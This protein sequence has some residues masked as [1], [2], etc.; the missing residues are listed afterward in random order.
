MLEFDQVPLH[1]HE[2]F[3]VPDT[4]SMLLGLHAI[5]LQ[6]QIVFVPQKFHENMII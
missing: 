6:R 2:K 5:F 3:L 4:E 1:G